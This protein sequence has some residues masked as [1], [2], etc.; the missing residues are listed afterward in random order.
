MVSF[1]MFITLILVIISTI[2]SY[3]PFAWVTIPFYNIKTAISVLRK[4][5]MKPSIFVFNSK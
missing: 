2:C 5:R 4:E 1:A 3:V